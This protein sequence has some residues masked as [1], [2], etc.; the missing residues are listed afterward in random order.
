MKREPFRK[1][2]YEKPFIEVIHTAFGEQLMQQT[3]FSNN[4][5]HNKAD[6]DGE[7]NAKQGW[8]DEDEEKDE[9]PPQWGISNRGV[10][11]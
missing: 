8:F 11:D 5:G 10:Y 2:T 1:Q 4:G 3:S 9:N 7:I 6:D